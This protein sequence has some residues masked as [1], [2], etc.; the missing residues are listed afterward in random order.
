MKVILLAAGRSSRMEPIGDKNFLNFLGKPLIWHQ[1]NFLERNKIKNVVIVG[2]NT[3]LEKLRETAK[4]FQMEVDVCEQKDLDLGMAGAV[5]AAKNLIDNNEEIL[6]FSSNDVVEDDALQSIMKG[7]DAE[8]YILGK[9][10][11][12]Y[13]PGGYLEID[14][15]GYI[16]N[17]IEKPGEGH[18]PSDMVNLVLHRY[19]N[20]EKFFKYLEKANSRSDDLYEVAMANMMKDG[21]KFKAV[22]YEG[23]WQP[24]KYPWHVQKVW[25]FLF[26]TAKKY[27]DK[28]VEIAKNAIIKGDV[29][30]EQGAK[31]FE[32][33]V[34]SGPAYLGKNVVVANNALVR[35][36]HLGD[37]STAGFNTEIARSYTNGK[38][39]TH[40]NYIGDSIID[41]NVSFGA[42]SVTGNLRL[43]EKEI[44]VKIKDQNIN[45]NSQKMGAIIG[46]NV[47]VG[48]NT[49]LMP[50]VKIGAGSFIGAGIMVSQNVEKTSFVRG[51]FEIKISENKTPPS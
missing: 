16:Q 43:D 26:K 21:S 4:S 30:I 23:F 50:G 37:N 45:T 10:V 12:K 48:V 17:V 32:G 1:L 38:L 8:A 20:F 9:K 49:S 18:E 36:S 25:K 6:I 19:T 34:V 33:A 40:I 3:N 27:I 2:S 47:R 15:D 11:T 5:L 39:R 35:E 42:G 31:I 24:I 14:K 22:A 7:K 51:K 41:D 29:I 13:F 44:S 28:S 46:K